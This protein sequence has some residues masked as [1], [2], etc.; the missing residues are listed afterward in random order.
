MAELRI[1]KINLNKQTNNQLGLKQLIDFETIDTPNISVGNTPNISDGETEISDEIQELNSPIKEQQSP[2]EINITTKTNKICESFKNNMKNL[3][4]YFNESYDKFNKRI[5]KLET[6]IINEKNLYDKLEHTKNNYK[7]Q[8]ELKKDDYTVEHRKLL[9]NQSLLYL[10][11]VIS[12][13][14]FFMYKFIF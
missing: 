1:R 13:I 2:I 6:K 12:I 10:Y 11:A 4:G 9:L 3:E 5:N 7:L 14:I 8:Y